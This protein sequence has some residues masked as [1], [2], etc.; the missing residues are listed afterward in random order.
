MAFSYVVQP[1]DTLY[2]IARRYGLNV[3]SILAANPSLQENVYLQPGQVLTV[4]ASHGS[5]YVIQAGDTLYDIARRFTISL[6]ALQAANPGIDPVRLRIG[7]TIVLPPARGER[8]V[9]IGNEYGYAEMNEDIRLLLQKYPFLQAGM[10]GQSVLGKPIPVIRIGNGEK[11]VHYN[12][13]F[14]ANEWITTPL[15]MRFIEEY[16]DSYQNQ[17]R[18]RG[19]DMAQL[20]AE[21]SLWVVPMV[22]PDGVE[23]VQEGAQPGNPYY[24]QLLEWNNGSADFR[25]WKA[26]I[27]GVDL[28]DQF[29]A[30]WEI[31]RDRRA[32]EGPGPRDYVGPFPLSEPES[33]AMANFTNQHSFRLVIAFHTQGQEIYWNYRDLEP[34]ESKGIADRFAAV[35]GYRAVKLTGSDA[36]YK[37]WFI[38]ELRRPGFTVE[39]GLGINP[40]PVSQ[41]NGMYDDVIGI[42][43]EGLKA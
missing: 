7:Q 19:R 10:I 28:N 36:G 27:R 34:P 42:L 4:P 14:H 41:F 8:I 17:T 24:S 2:R 16:A 13:A 25:R 32:V 18:L 26:N 39:A 23:L 11:Q 9:D 5:T 12:G 31:E 37:D 43:L 15:L 33:Q 29:P 30:H 22:N 21:A 3:P 1:G 40:L 20:Y 6:A 35:S 38:Q